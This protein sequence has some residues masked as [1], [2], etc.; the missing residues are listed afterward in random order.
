MVTRWVLVLK[1]FNTK[2]VSLIELLITLAIIGIMSPILFSI[3]IGGLNTYV[4]GTNYIDQQYK[5]NDAIAQIRR[6]VGRAKKVIVFGEEDLGRYDVE[7]VVFV[8]SSSNPVINIEDINADNYGDH[9]YHEWKFADEGLVLENGGAGEY[10]IVKDLDVDESSFEYFNFDKTLK[11][12]VKPL[13]NDKIVNKGSNIKK[14]ITTEFS[15][16]YKFVNIED[17][18]L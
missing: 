5:V 16:K 17:T 12:N 3:F 2:G 11:L 9:D 15:V 18:E 6:D 8:F 10:N 4:G 14:V 13:E 1:K 7:R